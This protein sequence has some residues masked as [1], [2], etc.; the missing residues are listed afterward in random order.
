M[1]SDLMEIFR[2]TALSRRALMML[3]GGSALLAACGGDDDD[4]DD[5]PTDGGSTQPTD[6]PEDVAEDSDT[7]EATATEAAPEETEP[8]N[9]EDSDGEPRQGGTLVMGFQNDQVLSLDPPVVNFG[10]VA[11]ELLPALFSSLVQ[12]NEALEVQPDLAESFEV[13]DDGLNYTF[14]LREG[15]TFHNGDT[16]TASDFVYTYER[17]INPDLA[18]PHANKLEVVSNIEAA[19]DVTLEITLSQAFAPFLAVACSR[20]PGRALT[21]VSQ[22]AIEEMGDDQYGLTPVGCGPFMIVPES[23]DVGEGFE[24]VAFEDWYGGRPFLDSIVVSLIPEPSSRASALEAGDINFMS[25]L[26]TTQYE[27]VAASDLFTV[28]GAPGTNWVS[29][30]IN[31]ARPPWDSV[32]ARMAVAKAVDVE[33]FNNVAFLGLAVPSTSAI[34]PAFGWVY[35]PFEEVDTPQAFN[36]DEAR[37]LAERAGIGGTTVSLMA[38]SD[39]VRQAEVIRGMLA[40]IDVNVEIDSLQTAAWNERWLAGD[41]DMMFNGSVADADPDDGHWNFFHSTGPWNTHGL[42]D[43]EIDQL[44]EETRAVVDQ[45]RRRELFREIARISQERVSFVFLYHAPD[46]LAFHNSVKGYVPIP[47]LRHFELVWLDE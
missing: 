3:A 22:R 31:H 32:D 19:D 29:L 34:A 20:G 15:L 18:S 44:L 24:M 45:D 9:E 30:V 14:T 6:T 8:A 26:P 40:E 2:T 12:F 7:P 13:T 46:Y 23:V 47:E 42:D 4:D 28:I 11:G 17:T 43:P 10:T 16:L 41:Y 21:P 27:V 5:E 33:E 37:A 1:A 35:Q 25:D 38:A 36:L 39:E